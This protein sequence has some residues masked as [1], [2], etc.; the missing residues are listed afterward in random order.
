MASDRR[1]IS[2]ATVWTAW[3][4][5]CSERK[6]ISPFLFHLDRTNVVQA[7]LGKEALLAQLIQLG[8]I[9]QSIPDLDFVPDFLEIYKNRKHTIETF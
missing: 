5:T 4:W 3:V 1:G 8:I 2:E 6:A 9:D 7:L